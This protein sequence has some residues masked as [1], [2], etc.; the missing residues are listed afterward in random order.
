MQIVTNF[1]DEELPTPTLIEGKALWPSQ[2]APGAR[3]SPGDG[4]SS[5]TRAWRSAPKLRRAD[6]PNDLTGQKLM[7]SAFH[8]ETG[9]LTDAKALMELFSGAF[10]HAQI[11]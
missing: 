2:A 1:S 8:P 10:G 3:L 7:R 4:L 9:P 6:R 11:L 5:C